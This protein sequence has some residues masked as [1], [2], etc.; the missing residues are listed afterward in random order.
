MSPRSD[1]L[2]KSCTRIFSQSTSVVRSFFLVCVCLLTLLF[3]VIHAI[4]QPLE[5]DSAQSDGNDLK[6][7]SLTKFST[8][9]RET[10][11]SIETNRFS[12]LSENLKKK[13]N[14]DTQERTQPLSTIRKI[15]ETK[16]RER[17]YTT[18]PRK[19]ESH[20]DEFCIHV[21]QW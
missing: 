18:D 17:K 16:D 19:M 13:K 12:I 15:F 14:Y 11:T 6:H 2:S 21:S 8:S 5:S 10:R 4:Y 3:V 1:L 7:H 9:I 20:N